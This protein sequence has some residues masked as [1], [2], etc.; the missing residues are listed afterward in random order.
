MERDLLAPVLDAEEHRS[1]LAAVGRGGPVERLVLVEEGPHAGRRGKRI[2]LVAAVLRAEGQHVE[3]VRGEDRRVSAAPVVLAVGAVDEG[4]VQV[5]VDAGDSPAIARV[6]ERVDLPAELGDG[7]SGNAQARSD[8][9]IDLLLRAQALEEGPLRIVPARPPGVDVHGAVEKQ[10][11]AVF[12]IVDRRGDG[13]ARRE[14]RDGR[15]AED[16]DPLHVPSRALGAE[17]DDELVA[18]E[19]IPGPSGPLAV[20]AA[21]AGALVLLFRSDRLLP[22]LRAELG[23]TVGERVDANLGGSATAPAALPIGAKEWPAPLDALEAARQLAGGEHVAADE[24]ELQG[25]VAGEAS[26]EAADFHAG[27]PSLVDV[28]LQDARGAQ[29]SFQPRERVAAAPQVTGD[30]IER[31]AKALPEDAG[32]RFAVLDAGEEVA[33]RQRFGARSRVGL[34]PLASAPLDIPGGRRL[35][36]P[37]ENVLAAEFG[38]AAQAHRPD[39]F[40]LGERKLDA[41]G[42]ERR[43]DG[44]EQS[45]RV[46]PDDEGDHLVAGNRIDRPASDDLPDGVL[47]ERPQAGEADGDGFLDGAERLRLVFGEIPRARLVDR[48]LGGP[49]GTARC[50]GAREEQDRGEEEEEARTHRALRCPPPALRGPRRRAAQARAIARVAWGASMS[51][52]HRGCTR[53]IG[54]SATSTPSVLIRRYRVSRS[55]LRGGAA[56]AKVPPPPSTASRRGFPPP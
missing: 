49:V 32:P 45:C 28:D 36:E 52:R 14:A 8:Q 4:G 20:L 16:L 3:E 26:V 2:V 1:D 18:V 22:R 27:K 12:R 50:G 46:Q 53:Y 6:G 31:A 17:V 7:K 11:D 29:A 48:F 37:I 54:S 33:R 41:V 39:G 25:H 19:S 35:E 42:I 40:V 56:P 34:F 38:E 23:A 47:V 44:G 21:R 30:A 10:V 5:R 43:N 55:S 13:E 51:P 24:P 9:P 15:V